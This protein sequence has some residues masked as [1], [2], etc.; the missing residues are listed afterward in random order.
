MSQDKLAKMFEIQKKINENLLNLNEKQKEEYSKQF[1]L[2]AMAEFTELLNETNWADWKKRKEVIQTNIYEEIIDAC[3]FL[4]NICLIW[5]MD[6]DMFFH[7]FERKS[8]VVEQR[9]RQM[10]ELDLI[11]KNNSKVCAIDLDGVLVQYPEPFIKYVNEIKRTS[12]KSLYDVKKDI[13]NKE[14]LQLKHS[15]RQDG[16]KLH[17]PPVDGASNFMNELKS[18][19]YSVVILTKR[20]YKQ[21][22]RLFADTKIN[23]DQSGIKYDAIVFDTEKHKAIVKELPQLEFMVEDNRE[24]ANEVGAWGYKC[25]LIDN[26][27]NHGHINDNVIRVSGL[28]E[29]LERIKNEQTN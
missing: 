4:L 22:Y 7:E 8:I 3:K 23:L 19:G 6:E 24:I 26:V 17:V 25:F 15:Y 28:S 21:Y 20:P 12:F 29:I 1:I 14:Y 2:A 18:L 9:L 13:S 11:K 5:G 16:M 27:Y 10:K